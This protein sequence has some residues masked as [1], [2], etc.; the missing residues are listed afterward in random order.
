MLRGGK[1]YL[2]GA[3]VF[4]QRV[5]KIFP[6]NWLA[7]VDNN[8]KL[9]GT[10]INGIP[11][12]A[13]E[14][15]KTDARV[16]VAV[17][18]R[19]GYYEIVKQLKRQGFST[20]QVVD[21]GGLLGRLVN[22]QY[23]EIPNVNRHHENEVFVDGGCFDGLTTRQFIEWSTRGYKKVYAFE[24][25]E[26]NRKNCAT[27]LEEFIKR[28]TAKILPFGLWNKTTKLSFNAT[29]GSGSS[30]G[31]GEET[32][33]VVALDDQ[34]F[35]D[36]ITFIKMDVEGAELRALQGAETIIKKNKPNLAICIYHKPEDVF[37][38]PQLILKYRQDY[39]FM[40]RHY[41]LTNCETVLYAI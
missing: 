4:G 27:E 5:S 21:F 9:W 3:G 10:E 36:D 34:P 31:N 23:F 8:D 19:S 40:V 32:V 14:E 26:S 37:E 28:G 39:R 25:D 12:I 15:M 1:A 2:F 7:I 17:R 11:V 20:Q 35:A 24:P 38:L 41:W 18:F 13:P 29:G 22:R 16:F 33:D 30:I 6:N